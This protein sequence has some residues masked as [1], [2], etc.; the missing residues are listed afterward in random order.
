MAA[1]AGYSGALIIPSTPSVALLNDTLSNASLDKVTWVESVAADR[2]WD[3]TVLP[4]IQAELD[5]V[6]TVTITGAPTGGTFTLTFGA[7]TTAAIAYNATAATVQTALQALAD[8][9]ANNVVVTGGPGPATAWTVEFTGTLGFANQATMT[10]T[11]S[12]TGGSS[13]TVTVTVAQNGQAWTTIS[14]SNY[15]VHYPSGVIVLNAPYL[16]ASVGIRA[17]SANYFP[18]AVLAN[19]TQ[20]AFDGQRTFQDN[21]SLQGDGM[22]GLQAGAGFKTFQPLLLEGAFTVTKF[23]V[24]ESQLGFAADIT[25][26]TLFII[27]GAEMSGNR[28][29]GYAYA[30]KASIKTDV[31]KLTDESLDFQLSGQFYLV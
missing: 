5:E 20:W 25:N 30:K 9:G 11:S 12:L 6:Q 17:H 24:P 21:T 27:S 1:I 13:P 26:G 7:A 8:I 4:V 31:Q 22:G 29:E 15:T 16:G 14:A 28:Y 10:A 19:I 18:W 23:W 2:Y 3:N